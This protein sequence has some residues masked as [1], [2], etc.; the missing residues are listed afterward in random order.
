[1][2]RWRTVIALLAAALVAPILPVV[3]GT[4]SSASAATFP[5]Q[6]GP[7]AF[8]RYDDD[9]ETSDIWLTTPDGA[10]KSSIYFGTRMGLLGALVALPAGFFAVTVHT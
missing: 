4:A 5:G 10:T 8:E 9:T 6:N 7:I 2:R 1:M 3:A